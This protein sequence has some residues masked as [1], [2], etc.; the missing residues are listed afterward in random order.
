MSRLIEGFA[1]YKEPDIPPD[2]TLVGMPIGTRLHR[3][4]RL[5]HGWRLWLATNDFRYGTFIELFDDGRVLHCTTRRDEGDDIF[6]VRPSD[7]TIRNQ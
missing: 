6:W 7:A 2:K 5:P 3:V 1:S 4:Y